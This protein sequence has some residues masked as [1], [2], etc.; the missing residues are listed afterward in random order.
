MLRIPKYMAGFT[1]IEAIMVMVI[2]G[3][4]AA[5]ATSF[6]APLRGYLDATARV[7]L[8]DV[9]DTALRRM[10]RDVHL[11]LP[12]SVRV[13]T[14]GSNRSLD[15]LATTG[16][17]RYRA[18]VDSLGAGNILDFT[19]ADTSFDVLG[20]T[21]DIANGDQIVVYNLGVSGADAYEGNTAA[22]HVR[23]AASNTGTGLS[24]VS[25]TSVN[26]LPFDSP[27][28]RFQIVHEQVRYLCDLSAGVIFRV[29]GFAI[30]TP[31]ATMPTGNSIGILA[32]GVT[33]CDFTY[34]PGATQRDGLITL[35]L[36]LSNRNSHPTNPDSV[37]LLHQVHVQNVP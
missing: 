24:S 29:A 18:V 20:P 10:A 22:T 5:L 12:N 17:G 9:A 31:T 25:I 36:T 23:R 11:A 33:G 37:T 16:G 6:A 15:F 3:I 14:L 27:G 19:A 32:T 30:E 26:R 8:S 7:D 1:L 4:L 35:N 13:N 21:V 28:H 2:T 34:T